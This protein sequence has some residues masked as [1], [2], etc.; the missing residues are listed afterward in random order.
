MSATLIATESTTRPGVFCRPIYHCDLLPQGC[1]G[2]V[3]FGGHV[4]TLTCLGRQPE[5]GYRLVS[6]YSMAVY[7]VDLS[8]PSCDCPDHTYRP[9]RACKHIT[10]LQNLTTDG[11]I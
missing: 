2:I 6:V 1:A 9:H 10:A 3:G 7:D 5:D 4:Y 8:V 11:V